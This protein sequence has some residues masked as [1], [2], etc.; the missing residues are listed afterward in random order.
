MKILQVSFDAGSLG[1]NKGCENGPDE[2]VKK[3]KNFSRKVYFENF[4]A[5]CNGNLNEVYEEIYEKCKN[6]DMM[7]GGDHSITY[8]GFRAF[9]E[10]FSNPGLLVFDAHPD[11]EVGTPTV[12][13]ESFAR[14]LIED[15]IL[16]KE[17][18]I[19]VG[20]RSFSDNEI[21]YL[22]ENK[23]KYF[24]MDKLFGN[25]QNVCDIIMEIC[26]DFDGLYVSVDIDVVDPA[27]APG[28]GCLES[29]GLSSQ[30]IL[31]F[32]RRVNL[33]KNL[34]FMDI[35]EVNPSK[36]INGITVELTNKILLELM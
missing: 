28:T 13:H 33:L 34:R 4:E 5:N 26:R 29:G 23:I 20:L 32:I 8:S 25:L 19:M 27:F 7:I 17:N 1:K 15:K 10:R 22:K 24:S 9:K 2:I 12:D 30:E 3:L 35:V 36:D 11:C 31:Y 14:K 16:K 6:V 18:L 21:A